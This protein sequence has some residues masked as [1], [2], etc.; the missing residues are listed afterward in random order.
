VSGDWLPPTDSAPPPSPAPEAAPAAARPAQ[1]V[2]HTAHYLSRVGAAVVDFVV[3][4]AIFLAVL[5]LVLLGGAGTLEQAMD[6]TLIAGSILS[7][8]YAPIMIA[9]TGGQTLGHRATDTRIVRQDGTPLDG[10][11]AVLREV[12]VKA[13]LFEGLGG[14]LIFIPTLLNY[15]WPLWDERDEALHDKL[16]RTRVVDV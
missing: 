3:R 12:L 11:G 5:L 8:A 15:L 9:R 4:A 2:G 13:L 14:L 10:G 7:A 6:I 1:A 16:C